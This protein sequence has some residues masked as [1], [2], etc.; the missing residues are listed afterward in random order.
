MIDHNTYTRPIL[1]GTI[2]GIIVFCILFCLVGLSPLV[3]SEYILTCIE[4]EEQRNLLIN[5]SKLEGMVFTLQR[6]IP[7]YGSLII[8]VI[9]F[10][11]WSQTGIA[12]S[13]AIDEIN[14]N[15]KN[16]K[17]RI[18]ELFDQANDLTQK[19]QMKYDAICSLAGKAISLDDLVN[20]INSKTNDGKA[21]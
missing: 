8:A 12:K 14:D 21:D 10:L 13:T 7:I 11:T 20:T 1:L 15:F 9:L 2:V 5:L 17:D 4:G 16:Y 18:E 3:S 19:I 6:V